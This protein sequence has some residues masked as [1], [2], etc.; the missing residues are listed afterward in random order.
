LLNAD[1]DPSAS[2][3]G[4]ME[5]SFARE[6]QLLR[7]GAGE[8]FEGEGILAITKGLLQA[9]VS[10]VTGYQGAPVSHLM[11]VLAD[12][13]DLMAELGVHF[14]PAANEAG[15]AA[16]LAASINYPLR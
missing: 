13:K 3:E 10:Y 1:S 14:E 4:C 15:A 8:V 5:R 7:R 9:G 11:D 12:A 2:R 6:V 16:M